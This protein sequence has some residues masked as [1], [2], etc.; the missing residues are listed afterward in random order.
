M[1]VAS[2]LP[3]HRHDTA[4]GLRN[5]RAGLH[6]ARLRP[7]GSVTIPDAPFGHVFVARGAVDVEGVG[8]VSQGDSIRLTGTGGQRLTATED[9]EVLIWEM[10]AELSS[11][12]PR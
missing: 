1:V 11:R 4:I 12:Q 6:A 2:G 5:R 10:H 3:R 9:A 7:G 8:L